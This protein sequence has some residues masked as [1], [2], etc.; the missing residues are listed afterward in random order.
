MLYKYPYRV[1]T[2][3]MIR[4]PKKIGQ[5]LMKEGFVK[6]SKKK[7]D[8]YFHEDGRVV[9]VHRHTGDIP[10]VTLYAIYRQAGWEID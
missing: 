7:H 9:T 8:V 1:H 4:N 3:V 10:P 6:V 5:R 2:K